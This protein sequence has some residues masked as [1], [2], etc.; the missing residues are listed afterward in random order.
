MNEDA[1][2]AGFLISPIS[3]AEKQ[4]KNRHLKPFCNIAKENTIG[5][6]AFVA[7]HNTKPKQKE[8]K[9]VRVHLRNQGNHHPGDGATKT[10]TRSPFTVTDLSSC[11]GFATSSCSCWCRVYF[12][13]TWPDDIL[14]RLNFSLD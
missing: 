7:K 8:E 3:W 14:Q 4:S 5:A 6:A 1:N 2:N 9:A 11:S 10:Q 13:T 12:E